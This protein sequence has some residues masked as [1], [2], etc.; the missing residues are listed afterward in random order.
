M[1]KKKTHSLIKKYYNCQKLLTI[2]WTC[3]IDL[4]D[5]EVPQPFDLWGKKSLQSVI[6]WGMPVLL[7]KNNMSPGKP[8]SQESMWSRPYL[9]ISPPGQ[10]SSGVGLDGDG[11]HANQLVQTANKIS[12]T[13]LLND[14]GCPRLLQGRC[15]NSF[16][17]LRRTWSPSVIHR[18]LTSTIRHDELVQLFPTKE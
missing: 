2:I 11:G 7:V 12:T 3:W 10:E 17:W 15:R 4:L 16:P 8:V 6:K 18:A 5:T 13:V 9:S 14:D 1:S